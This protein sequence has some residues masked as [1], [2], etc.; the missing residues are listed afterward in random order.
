MEN[1]GRAGHTTNDNIIRRMRISC[2]ITK[3]TGTHSEYVIFVTF[4][5]KI[6][7]VGAPLSFFLGGGGGERR[8]YN[9]LGHINTRCIG[10]ENFIL[11]IY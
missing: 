8:R 11:C 3:A 6:C 10:T 1:Y 5:N 4:H 9:I 2:W 7:Y